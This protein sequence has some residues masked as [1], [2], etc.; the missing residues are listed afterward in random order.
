MTDLRP[1]P[2]VT[3]PYREQNCT[4]APERKP[5]ILLHGFGG[6]SQSYTHIQTALST[7]RRS[8]AFDLPG[9][10]QALDWPVVGNASVAAKAVLQS[11]EAMDLDR[12]HLVGHSMGGA[13]AAIAALKEPDRFA[14]L[15]L[16]APGGFGP[17]INYK[18]LRRY[19]SASEP[20][21][22]EI[23][24][25]QFFGWEF[26][27][28]KFLARTAAEARSKPGTNATLEAIVEELL[29][30]TVQKT[31]P[32]KELAKLPLPIKVIWGTQDRV[33]PTRQAHKLPGEIATHV[34]DKVGHM[35]HLEVA[36]A[37]V[38]LILQNASVE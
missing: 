18:L 21:L 29:D 5:V 12:V 4:K 35:P 15:T 26:R 17:E 34:F 1:N 7:T 30:G 28:P 8:I 25:E 23:L 14:S 31:L 37:V 16:L 2:R 22:M 33:L 13:A 11:L 9:H 27:L 32:V 10:G 36:D 20:E 24:L 19:A 3:L 38:R 6:D